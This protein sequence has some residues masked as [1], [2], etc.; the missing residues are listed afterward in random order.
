[1]QSFQDFRGLLLDLRYMTPKLCYR[2]SAAASETLDRSSIS[3]RN[4]IK[5]IKTP[6]SLSITI[7]GVQAN[8][9]N[10]TN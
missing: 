1:M 9:T 3:R 6:K 10:K 8:D 4:L 2:L 7:V 5:Q